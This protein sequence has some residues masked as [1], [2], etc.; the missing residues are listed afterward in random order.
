MYDV[1]K[2]GAYL[3]DIPHTFSSNAYSPYNGSGGNLLTATFPLAP[4]PA[5]QPPGN[6][7]ELH[8]G[9]RPA[10]RRRLLR[11]AEEQP[12]VLPRRRQPGDV[13]RHQGRLPRPTARARAT[14]TSTSRSR[15]DFT[16]SN[17]GVE[18]GY[19]TSK[20]TFAVRWDYSKFDNDNETLRWTNPYFGGNQPRHEL[21]R[22]GQ[23]VQQVHAHRQLPR[24]AVEV[25]GFGALHLGEDDQR[26]DPRADGAQHRTGVRADAARARQLQRRERQPVVRAGVDRDADGERRLARLLLLD[27]AARTSPTSSSIGNAPTQPLASGLGCGNVAGPHAEHLACRQLRER[28]LQLHQEQRRL[29]RVVE[30]PARPAR[31]LRLGLHRPRPDAP[32]LRQGA[33]EQVVG[34]VQEHDARHAVRPAQV[35]VHQARLDAQLHDARA[36]ARTTRTTCSRT[37]RRSTC[38]AARPTSSS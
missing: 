37:R 1:F 32:R 6:W 27:Q 10:R 29:R 21:P 38:R 36:H 34:R 14:A 33:L 28:E 7:N 12:V 23:H 19:Q 3:N 31:R 8:A 18:G 9:L 15:H 5:P 17:C 35:P 2:A 30:V 20:A 13:Q 25:G 26:R 4:L 24:P 16:T 11:V 22:A